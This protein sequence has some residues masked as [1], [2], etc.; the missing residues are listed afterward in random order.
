[1]VSLAAQVLC[2]SHMTCV[3]LRQFRSERGLQQTSYAPSLARLKYCRCCAGSPPVTLLACR[4][5]RLRSGPVCL[6]KPYHGLSLHSASCTLQRG[7]R[8]EFAKVSPHRHPRARRVEWRARCISSIAEICT[9]L[10]SCYLLSRTCIIDKS[11]A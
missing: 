2:R 8:D 1:M 10:A 3:W 6:P 7:T 11:R 5:K 4:G 9:T